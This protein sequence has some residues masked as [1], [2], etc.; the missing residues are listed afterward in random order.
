ML[1]LWSSW[2]SNVSVC[3]VRIWVLLCG[4]FPIPFPASWLNSSRFLS[5]IT[6]CCDTPSFSGEYTRITNHRST[7]IL[8]QAKGRFLGLS[9]WDGG[10]TCLSLAK[11]WLKKYVF[12][13]KM[14]LFRQKCHC[15]I[16][17]FLKNRWKN[18]FWIICAQNLV[19]HVTTYFPLN[20]F[21]PIKSTYICQ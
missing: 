21:P 20:Y 13:M 4:L 12:K 1:F 6:P 11:W 19:F 2:E 8:T 14:L 3:R 15:Y 9:R 7:N 16:T 18:N 5:S 10:N 17:P